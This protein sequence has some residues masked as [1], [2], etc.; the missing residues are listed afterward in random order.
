MP[1]DLSRP[2]LVVCSTPFQ[3][4][5]RRAQ[6]KRVR[7]DQEDGEDNVEIVS[8]KKNRCTIAKKSQKQSKKLL[9]QYVKDSI[10]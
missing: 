2:V 1:Q 6:Q 7:D 5:A 8:P 9:A 4:F 10:L 3:V